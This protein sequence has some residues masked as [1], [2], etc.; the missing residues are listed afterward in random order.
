MIG[1]PYPNPSSPEMKEKMRYFEA[2]G[3]FHD[4]ASCLVGYTNLFKICVHRSTSRRRQTVLWKHMLT[5]RKSIYWWAFL[6]QAVLRVQLIITCRDWEDATLF[7]GRAIRH[8]NDHAA[9]ILMDERYSEQRIFGKLPRWIS[10]WS[11]CILGSMKHVP[12]IYVLEWY[13]SK[14]DRSVFDSQTHHC[15]S[16]GKLVAGLHKFFKFHRKWLRN[17]SYDHNFYV[18]LDW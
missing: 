10:R 18:G 4:C 16:F 9:I 11:M 12:F 7:P 1:L 17:L 2:R 15:N 14:S 3:F 5:C 13:L 6:T 8:A